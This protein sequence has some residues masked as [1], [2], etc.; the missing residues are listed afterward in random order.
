MAIAPRKTSEY[1]IRSFEVSKFRGFEVSGFRGFEVSRFRGSEVLESIP[2]G[3]KDEKSAAKENEWK[4]D[5]LDAL[6]DR[7]VERLARVRILKLLEGALVDP[8]AAHDERMVDGY[9]ALLESVI[10]IGVRTRL[11][12]ARVLAHRAGVGPAVDLELLE[13]HEV[14]W[15]VV[16][17]VLPA[18]ASHNAAVLSGAKTQITV[19]RACKFVV[20][21]S[22]QDERKAKVERQ[23][24]RTPPCERGGD[25]AHGRERAHSAY[26]RVVLHEV[27]RLLRPAARKRHG[28]GGSGEQNRNRD[29]RRYRPSVHSVRA[30][31]R[32]SAAPRRGDWHRRCLRNARRR[33]PT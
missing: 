26:R 27:K 1:K 9:L 24:C 25:Q 8:P 30:S 29:A 32:Y 14:L 13:A 2:E 17:N 7:E 12:A 33:D 15:P 28:C 23:H 22:P 10:G 21:P 31:S 16:R 3:A 6:E 4:A 19:A 11:H 5:V 20:R 18:V